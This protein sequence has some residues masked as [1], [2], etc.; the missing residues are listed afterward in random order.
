MKRKFSDQEKE[1]ICMDYIR[2]RTHITMEELAA[3]YSCS[4]G[5]IYNILDEY[6]ILRRGRGR[7]LAK[8][9]ARRGYADKT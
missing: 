1:N 6:N 3:K 8:R 7:D 2:P 4:I 5:T 9:Q